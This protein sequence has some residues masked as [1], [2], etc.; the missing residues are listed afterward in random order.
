[1]GTVAI[2]LLSLYYGKTLERIY[3]RGS[4]NAA[5]RLRFAA[6]CLLVLVSTAIVPTFAVSRY[7]QTLLR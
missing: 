6:V 1:M 5:T 2:V 3:L 4:Q 7:L